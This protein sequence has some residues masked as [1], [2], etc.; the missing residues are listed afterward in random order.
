M[1]LLSG[2]DASVQLADG[3]LHRWVRQPA[4]TACSGRA[5][6]RESRARGSLPS[7]EVP[8]EGPYENPGPR[9]A[10]RVLRSVPR[11]RGTEA[12]GVVL[13]AEWDSAVPTGVSGTASGAG[14]GM[15]GS[16]LTG[17][18]RRL[19][20]QRTMV[21]LTCDICGGEK[22]GDET[23]TV[24]LDGASYEVDLCA[25]H[26]KQLRDA[27][28]PFTAAGRRVSSRGGRR[29]GAAGG[30]DRAR[31]Q[32]IRAWARKKGIKVSER[33]RISAE[34]IAQYEASGGK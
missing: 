23:L 25:K 29:R 4:A 22:A 1:I 15:I 26:A 12:A 27:V 28:A 31:T 11:T 16:T 14:S 24:G 6:A 9:E 5:A 17:R 21:L 8:P 10:V 34:V 19:M 3:A 18:K 30:G 13:C 2:G 32:A 20:A 7:A 33:G